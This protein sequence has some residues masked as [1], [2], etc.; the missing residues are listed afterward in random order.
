MTVAPP[1]LSRV[2]DSSVDRAAGSAA[3]VARTAVRTVA[4]TAVRSAAAALLAAVVVLL[5]TIGPASTASAHD[6]VES[7]N[8]A[9]G[10]TVASLP[11]DL[12]IT[13]DNTPG[14]L[15]STI[16]VKDAS[17]KDWAQGN[18]QVVDHVVT[19]KLA[20]GGPAGKYTVLWRLVSSDSHP[21]EG[22]FSFTAVGGVAGG[23][24]SAA[25]T[26]APAQT[27]TAAVP[28]AQPAAGFPWGI[29]VTIVVLVLAVA[30]LGI[31]ARRRLNR[32]E[33]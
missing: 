29:V 32:A 7:T 31:F 6:V 22:T 1:N 16:Q 25:N 26:A 20:A 13:L 11:A 2:V 5:A 4:R 17:G 18:V 27:T 9:S 15:G 33:D 30:A 10:S 8:P 28:A 3:G 14:A 24:A 12:T 19:Q 23:D 21:I